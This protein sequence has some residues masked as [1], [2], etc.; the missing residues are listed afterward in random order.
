[1]IILAHITMNAGEDIPGS[2]I[3]F[4]LQEN[5]QYFDKVIVIDGNLTEEAKQYYSK[6]KN[7]EV[8]EDVQTGAPF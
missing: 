1:M 7:L 2:T 6:F 5:A 4:H 8:A 3:K